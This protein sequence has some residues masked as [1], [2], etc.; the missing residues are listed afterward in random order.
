MCGYRPGW[1]SVNSHLGWT[2]VRLDTQNKGSKAGRIIPGVGGGGG[3]Y[4][5]LRKE[6]LRG[7]I[8]VVQD[9][10]GELRGANDAAQCPRRALRGASFLAPTILSDLGGGSYVVQSMRYEL[11]GA[12]YAVQYMRCA[13][14][15][16]G[17]AVQS[18]LS[19]P[20][21]P[22]CAVQ[23]T[24]CDLHGVSYAVQLMRCNLR[25]VSYAVQ[26]MLTNMKLP[27]SNS[28]ANIPPTHPLLGRQ[29]SSGNDCT[30]QVIRYVNKAFGRI[31]TCARACRPHGNM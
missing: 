13:I 27:P 2:Y 5:L 20:R 28:R 9:M 14:Y 17:Y 19:N 15:G 6:N 26:Y 1:N 4:F 31:P 12:R 10:R 7:A 24:L 16:V 3:V 23:F 22:I 25:C 29:N 8:Y 11:C 18:L 30:Y 21:R